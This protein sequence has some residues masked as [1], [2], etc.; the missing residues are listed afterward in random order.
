MFVFWAGKT[1][2]QIIT[3][4]IWQILNIIPVKTFCQIVKRAKRIRGIF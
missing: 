2:Q 1:P 4:I 3:I